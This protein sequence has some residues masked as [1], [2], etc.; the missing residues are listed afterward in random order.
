MKKFIYKAISMAVICV[1]FGQLSMAQ[2]PAA[3]MPPSK[4]EAPEKAEQT[5]IVIRQKGDKDTKLTL[6]IKNGDY[7]I[8]GKPLEKFDDENVIV[9]KR[10]LNDVDVNIPQSVFRVNPWN[11]E[12]MER[13][14]NN[15]D[16][17]RKIQKSIQIRMNSA[18]L[19]V[20]SRK[21]EKGGATVLE[22][23][24]GSPAEKA[25][26]KKADVITKVND[27]KIESPENLFETIH[28]LKPGDK[29]KILLTRDGKEQTV[30]ATL[31]KPDYTKMKDLKEL[32]NFNYNYNYKMPPMPDMKGLGMEGL[33]G[34]ARQPKIGIKAQDAEDGKGVNVL[35]VEDSS[36]AA[37]GGLKKGDIIVQ[38]DG[39]EVNST[40][41]LIDQL[42]EARKK[43][44]VKIKILRG[45][46]SREI[47]IKI[48]RKLRTAEL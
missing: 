21:A 39:T 4:P 13:E 12:R 14:L 41:E 5:E 29:V 8:N 7:F 10:D 37:R 2:A 11:D 36:S 40:G 30:V 19:G 35:E 31:D 47:E 25:G 38:F 43:S 26:I 9:E 6:E 20:S 1:S 23:T 33:W 27:V 22:V 18:F 3:P 28:N 24:E 32:K 42:Q 46:E 44:T 15:Q 45:G 17:Q 34:E 16:M 48:P